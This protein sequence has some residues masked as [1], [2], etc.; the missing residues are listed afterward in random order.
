[1]EIMSFMCSTE[2]TATV[3]LEVTN[4]LRFKDMAVDE[5]ISSPVFKVGGYDWE[6]RFYPG[7]DDDGHASCYLYLL[8][9]TDD[10]VSVKCAVSMLEK[11][12]QEQVVSY[13]IS[14]RIFSWVKF[15]F[16][17]WGYKNFVDS[18]KLESLSTQNGDGC[19]TIVCALTVTL[20][21]SSL[22]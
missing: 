14:K 5:F 6:I 12:G 22:R 1:M 19:F 9:E 2:S 18:A 17:S 10:D 8:N 11:K 7:E 21:R 13:V 3:T 15:D 16:S 20:S 4:Y